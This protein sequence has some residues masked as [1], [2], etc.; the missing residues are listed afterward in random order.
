MPGP[1]GLAPDDAE[2]I[3]RS[4][5]GDR[6]AFALLVERHHAA[7]FRFLRGMASDAAAAEDA[8]QD[9]FAA[10]WTGAPGFRG[11]ASG[12]SWLFTL[13]RN[14]LSRRYRRLEHRRGNVESFDSMEPLAALGEAAGW[15]DA[16]CGDRVLSA[17]EDRDR[18]RKGLRALSTEDRELLV[19]LDVE[20][21]SAR[22]A[23]EAL[24]MKVGALKSRLHRARLRLLA[25]LGK[26]EPHEG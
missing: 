21:L 15:G 8:L 1:N 17:L 10:A 6:H 22:E 11:E 12:R 2:L 7:L 5:G 25:Q 4:A 3:R 18:V 19:R 9:A 20:E 13:A 24:G 23:A 14:A 26:E 16:A